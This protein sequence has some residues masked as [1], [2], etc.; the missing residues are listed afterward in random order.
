MTWSLKYDEH[1]V[2]RALG[3]P[4]CNKF[5]CVINWCSQAT[6]HGPLAGISVRAL[7]MIVVQALILTCPLPLI[8]YVGDHITALHHNALAA[9]NHGKALRLFCEMWCDPACKVCD[10]SSGK[11]VMYHK[12]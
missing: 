3:L 10:V 6:F 8:A 5:Q 4:T 7:G 11:V 2:Q 9:M 1:T 12:M